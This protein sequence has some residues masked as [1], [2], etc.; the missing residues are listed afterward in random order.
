MRRIV[1]ISLV[2]LAAL[3]GC[4]VDLLAPSEARPL[5]GAKNDPRPRIA[6]CYNRADSTPRQ[7]MTLARGTCGTGT[8]PR[9]VDDAINP[10]AC[11]VLLPS[12]VTFACERE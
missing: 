9:F 5:P 1:G 2:L 4:A 3:T 8:T 11:P 6:Y 12:R 7:L 10:S